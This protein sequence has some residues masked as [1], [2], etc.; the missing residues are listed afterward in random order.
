MKE[1][2]DKYLAKEDG[3][4]IISSQTIAEVGRFSNQHL[5]KLINKI[6]CTLAI[7]LEKR[8]KIVKE[9]DTCLLKAYFDYA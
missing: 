4:S 5:G 2:A 7:G 3:K 6:G 9:V 1:D 8:V